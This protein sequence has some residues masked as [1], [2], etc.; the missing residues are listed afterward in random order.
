M[1][2]AAVYLLSK[3]AMYMK[4]PCQQKDT[5]NEHIYRVYS[6]TKN[7]YKC[8]LPLYPLCIQSFLLFLIQDHCHK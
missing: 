7:P 5:Q 1:N 8:P 2:L 6:I 3:T 4:K